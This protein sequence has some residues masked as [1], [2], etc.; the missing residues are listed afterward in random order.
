[1]E[2]NDDRSFRG[3][4]FFIM[5]LG[6]RFAFSQAAGTMGQSF[7]VVFHFS[8]P[9]IGCQV[10]YSFGKFVAGQ[11]FAANAGGGLLYMQIAGFFIAE[12]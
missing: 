12:I 9:V 6:W 5:Q 3:T 2:K 7:P 4:R 10:D 11:V 8:L 1:M